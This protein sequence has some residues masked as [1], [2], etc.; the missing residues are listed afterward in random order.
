MFLSSTNAWASLLKL[1]ITFR[2]ICWWAS[3]RNICWWAWIAFPCKLNYLTNSI[4]WTH[5]AVSSCIDLMLFEEIILFIL[6]V[7]FTS[8]R[9]MSQRGNYTS[10]FCSE[11]SFLTVGVFTISLSPCTE[12]F[13]FPISKRLPSCFK[14]S[15]QNCIDKYNTYRSPSFPSLLFW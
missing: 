1:Q 14:S 9:I 2:N 7:I 12:I 10:F 13:P 8:C 6:F 3:F 4:Y 11:T 5:L 15:K